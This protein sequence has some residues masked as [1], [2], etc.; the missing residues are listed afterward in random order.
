MPPIISEP[1]MSSY[2]TKEGGGVLPT[3]KLHTHTH[4]HTHTH[5]KTLCQYE[6]KPAKRRGCTRGQRAKV[7]LARS[8]IA[9]AAEHAFYWSPVAEKQNFLAECTDTKVCHLCLCKSFPA[10]L[11]FLVCTKLKLNILAPPSCPQQTH[12]PS[13]H[14]YLSTPRNP[15]CEHVVRVHVLLQFLQWVQ[16]V[17]R[18]T[19]E[20]WIVSVPIT[21]PCKN[22]TS[23]LKTARPN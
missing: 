18:V 11:V 16:Q 21:V 6:P 1:F 23:V 8:P 22:T 19:A 4:T 2:V 12:T 9:P 10:I 7:Q 3:E 15:P 14:S 20:P 17:V 13:H 5:S